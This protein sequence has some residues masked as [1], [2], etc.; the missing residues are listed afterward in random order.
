MNVSQSPQLYFGDQEAQ[1][2]SHPVGIHPIICLKS[3]YFTD[4]SSPHAQPVMIKLSLV[5]YLMSQLQVESG[6]D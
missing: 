1:V 3:S 2:S 5:L 4:C 6:T